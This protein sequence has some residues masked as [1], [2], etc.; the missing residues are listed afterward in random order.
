MNKSVLFLNS[1]RTYHSEANLLGLWSIRKPTATR[2]IR[3]L[4][5]WFMADGDGKSF[6]DGLTAILCALVRR[7][8]NFRGKATNPEEFAS[9][10]AKG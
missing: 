7:L 6:V 3:I 9:L 1:Y 8:C 5:Y 4:G 2:K 10:L